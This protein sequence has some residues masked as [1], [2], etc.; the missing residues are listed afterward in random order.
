MTKTRT[1]NSIPIAVSL[2]IIINTFLLIPQASALEP[3]Y[4]EKVFNQKCSGC[5]TVGGG[6]KIG[7][8]L[9]GVIDRRGEDWVFSYIENPEKMKEGE[10]PIALEL[11]AKWQMS[12]P[13]LGLSESD[14]RAVMDYLKAE[15]IST[16]APEAVI[17]DGDATTGARLFNGK[18]KFANGGP[19]CINCHSFGGTSGGTLGPDLSGFYSKVGKA[20]VFSVLESIAF[21]T[22]RPI[23]KDNPLAEYEIADLAEYLAGAVINRNNGSGMLYGYGLAGVIILLILSTIIWKDRHKNVRE[24]L[25][26][27]AS[28]GRETS[29]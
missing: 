25:I 19:A 11:D 15:P 13:S 3:P 23:Y 6:D 12:M 27:S 29:R 7:P 8:D 18:T 14:I 10:D 24:N 1:T 22:M 17:P 4:G 21:P 9:K 16:P 5:H 20:G 28:R 2:I 26:L